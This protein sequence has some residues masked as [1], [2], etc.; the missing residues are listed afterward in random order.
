MSEATILHRRYHEA[1][2]RRDFA[3][4]EA[5][6]APGA[7]YRSMGVGALEGRTA[8]LAA[9]RTYFERHPD[10]TDG[11]DGIEDAGPGVSLAKWWL[12]ATDMETGATIERRG[13]ERLTLDSAGR[14]VLVE[15]EDEA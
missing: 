12:R 4:I 2:R 13:A 10:Q 3:A 15:V 14:I 8:I 5:M 1:I 7:A 11:D 6:M 9:F